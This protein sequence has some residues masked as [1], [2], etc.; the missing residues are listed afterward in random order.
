[1]RQWPGHPW[2]GPAAALGQGR[3][4]VPVAPVA[5]DT[6]TMNGPQHPRRCQER[7]AP[8]ASAAAPAPSLKQPWPWAD[9][10]Q[11]FIVTSNLAVAFRRGAGGGAASSADAMIS[12]AL[13][14][15][16]A[17]VISP[18]PGLQQRV[19]VAVR[20]LLLSCCAT[21]SLVALIQ[22]ARAETIRLTPEQIERL[23]EAREKSRP[24]CAEQLG[25]TP[26][27]VMARV[28]SRRRIQV[29]A[30]RNRATL[31]ALPPGI[32]EVSYRSLPSPCLSNP[33]GADR[34]R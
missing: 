3:C 1:M 24:T 26:E 16:C 8:R 25:L 9:V 22:P 11:R 28:G 13:S 31:R 23:R 7:V 17:A 5:H 18:A 14:T 34:D 6:D 21:A 19:A 2:A 30:S 15:D 10:V 29:I 20:I 33:G 32:P 12:S 4:K 27:Q